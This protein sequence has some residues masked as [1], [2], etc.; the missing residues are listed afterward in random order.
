MIPI[1]P[2]P[3]SAVEVGAVS[4]RSALGAVAAAN[5]SAREMQVGRSVPV[6]LPACWRTVGMLVVAA[7]AEAGEKKLCSVDVGVSRTVL[8]PDVRLWRVC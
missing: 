2:I 4:G 7:G 6:W 5:A 3:A 1:S 8:I